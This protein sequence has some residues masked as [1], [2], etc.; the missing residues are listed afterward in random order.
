MSAFVLVHGA[1]GGGWAWRL[2]TPLLRAAGHDVFP[3]TLTGLGERAHLASPSVDLDTHIRD[4][5]ATIEYEDLHDVVLVG[6]SYGGTV[7]TGVLGDMPERI[8]R[9]VY[10]DAQV[11]ERGQAVIDLLEPPLRDFIIAS[12]VEMATP[13][14]VEDESM[15]WYVAKIR[16]HPLATWRQP[17]RSA[18]P[19]ADA[20]PRTFIAC[21][22]QEGGA[23]RA[24]PLRGQRNWNVV[25][26]DS[27]HFPMARCP[28]K[29]ADLLLA[30]A[31]G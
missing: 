8:A 4:V 11:P 14:V 1:W 28:D 2:V 29:L 7:I 6:H 15:A 12:K 31:A 5:T 3:V 25:Q 9:L 26:I 17:L 22:N 19:G 21:T 20:V 13:P 10:V 16:S 18:K 23:A 24:E 27:D 30:A